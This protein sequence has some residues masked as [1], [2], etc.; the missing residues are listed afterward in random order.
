MYAEYPE[1]RQ[2]VENALK[3][4]IKVLKGKQWQYQIQV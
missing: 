1:V 3:T 4:K 2:A